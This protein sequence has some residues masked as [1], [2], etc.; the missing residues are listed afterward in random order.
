MV[1][2]HLAC[3]IQKKSIEVDLAF[4]DSSDFY[5]HLHRARMEATHRPIEL[6]E[7]L[8]SLLQAGI[9]VVAILAILLPFGPLPPLALLLSTAPALY[10][11]VKMAQRRHRW[12]QS[13]TIEN[14]RS[15][16]YDTL[17][18]DSGSAAE[19]RLYD[20]GDHFV[21]AFQKVRER[22][23]NERLI[24]A[25][26]ES[27]SELWAGAV[28]LLILAGT[29]AWMARLA[30]YGSVSLGDLAL[31]YQAVNQGFGLSRTLLDNLGKI[32]ENSL[33]LGNLF[34]FLDLKP[35]IVSAPDACPLPSP[36]LYGIQFRNVSFHYP[37]SNRQVLCD[38]NLE[39]R[40]GQ[41][42]ALVGPN[43]TGKSTL[44]KLLCR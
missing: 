21:R 26:Q 14:R 41:M 39:V 18:T 31:F 36:L 17:L 43:G 2:D 22:L 6:L 30:I 25:R 16:Y 32:Y 27:V 9:T 37:G 42:V 29:M 12:N 33:F 15:W 23:R 40:P 34:E 38:F 20:L 35:Q 13:T 8:G 4:Y 7:G 19:M 5:D 44:I 1:R 10:V 3:L 24:L 11:V 28:A